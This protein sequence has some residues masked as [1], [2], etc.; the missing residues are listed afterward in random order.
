MFENEIEPKR[1][2]R[3]NIPREFWMWVTEERAQ[4]MVR[5]RD[6]CGIAMIGM[7]PNANLD[8]VFIGGEGHVQR[9]TGKMAICWSSA[10]SKMDL[11]PFWA[12][13]K[14][15]ENEEE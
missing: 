4:L 15:L 7:Y 13:V 11:N 9:P 8:T 6:D 2:G 10:V 1:C 14:E 5:A 3:Q 12:R